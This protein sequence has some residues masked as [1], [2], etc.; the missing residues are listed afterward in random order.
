MGVTTEDRM[1][2]GK[3]PGSAGSGEPRATRELRW[4]ARRKE[5]GRPATPA[6]RVA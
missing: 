1:E 3:A 6:W 4:S 5:G 2:E